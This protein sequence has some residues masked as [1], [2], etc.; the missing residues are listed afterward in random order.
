MFANILTE[1]FGHHQGN[2]AQMATQLKHQQK[3]SDVKLIAED[4]LH[5][6]EPTEKPLQD[7]HKF[8]TCFIN[9]LLFM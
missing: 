7:F 6:Y 8:G 5:I 3:F 1:C 2:F 4:L 9:A